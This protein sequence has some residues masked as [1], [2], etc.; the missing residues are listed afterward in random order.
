MR[1][2][3]LHIFIFIGNLSVFSQIIPDEP[4]KPLFP[5]QIPDSLNQYRYLIED[6]IVEDD[7]LQEYY[8]E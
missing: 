5:T 8:G 7:I 4:A 1:Y 3:L 2:G 6:E